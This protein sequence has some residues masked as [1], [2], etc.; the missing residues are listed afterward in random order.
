M[1]TS[2]ANSVAASSARIAVLRIAVLKCEETN[3]RYHKTHVVEYAELWHQ[4]F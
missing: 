2:A 3:A 1:Q 4:R